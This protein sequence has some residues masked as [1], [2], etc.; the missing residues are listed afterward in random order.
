M[1][2]IVVLCAIN[3]VS[4]RWGA[5]GQNGS[6]GR[7]LPSRWLERTTAMPQ[8]PRGLRGGSIAAAEYTPRRELV[9]PVGFEPTTK[10]L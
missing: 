5:A 8:M 3:V 9:G 2:I 7:L 4:T 6:T 1:G 10:G